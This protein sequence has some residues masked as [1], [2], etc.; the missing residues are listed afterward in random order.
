MQLSSGWI[1]DDAHIHEFET[2]TLKCPSFWSPASFSLPDKLIFSTG[3]LDSG[4]S[5]I[6]I[7]EASEA[8]WSQ[9]AWFQ[10]KLHLYLCQGPIE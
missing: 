4:L 8:N 3:I 7:R 2:Q 9:L 10:V 1:E 6:T 5:L